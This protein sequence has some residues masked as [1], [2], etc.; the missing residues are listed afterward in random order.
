[1]NQYPSISI[2]AIINLII[3]YQFKIIPHILQLWVELTL[4]IYMYNKSAGQQYI[5]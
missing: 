1:M 2:P 5:R 3:N 4:R